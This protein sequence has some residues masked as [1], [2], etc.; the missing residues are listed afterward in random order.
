M[1]N[2]RTGQRHVISFPV[3]LNWKDEDGKEVME[4]GLTENIG[5][6]GTLV[7]LPRL[8]PAVGSTVK[9][10]VT[11][12]P[13]DEVTVPAEV[14]RL[15]RNAAHPQAALEVTKSIKLWRE[16]VWAYAGAMLEDEEPEGLDDW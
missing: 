6:S 10:T 3:R 11:E 15:V 12:N 16:K 7:F 13:E 9:L 8:L 1:E 2:R 4:E 14:L 5:P